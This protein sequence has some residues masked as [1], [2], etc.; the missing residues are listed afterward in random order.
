MNHIPVLTAVG[1]R[2]RGERERDDCVHDSSFP[3]PQT[4][5]QYGAGEKYAEGPPR[6]GGV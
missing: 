3:L 4:Q 1:D 5:G 2:G 6:I